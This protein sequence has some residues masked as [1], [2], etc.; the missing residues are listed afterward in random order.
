M[1]LS[2]AVNFIITPKG[3]IIKFSPEIPLSFSSLLSCSLWNA[4]TLRKPR[5]DTGLQLGECL[6]VVTFPSSMR[7]DTFRENFTFIRVSI[8][9]EKISYSFEGGHTAGPGN[10][11]GVLS[12]TPATNDRVFGP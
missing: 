11:P 10:F 2:H 3:V 7:G 5:V 12:E 8:L 6:G 4:F 1:G 9:S